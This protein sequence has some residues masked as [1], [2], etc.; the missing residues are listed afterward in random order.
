[1]PTTIGGRTRR[2]KARITGNS[3]P[4]SSQAGCGDYRP[5]FTAQLLGLVN[6]VIRPQLVLLTLP[7]TVLTLALSGLVINGLLFGTVASFLQGRQVRGVWAAFL[8]TFYDTLA[9]VI[10]KA[11]I[12]AD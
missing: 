2:K 7:V 3:R 8:R 12:K 4:P 6:A 10:K 5:W 1:V 9:P 11:G